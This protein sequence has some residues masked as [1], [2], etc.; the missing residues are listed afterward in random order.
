[1][2]PEGQ[3]ATA[4]YVA[5]AIYMLLVFGIGGYTRRLIRG[6]EDYFACGRRVPWW[7]AAISHHISG[8]SAF[9]FVGFA[10]VGYTHGFSV[11]TLFAIPCFIAMALGAFVW[12]PRW[13]RLAVITPAQYLEQRFNNLVRQLI[14]WSGI[15]VKFV[16]EGAK[17]YSLAKVVSACTRLRQAHVV[18]G[19][20]VITIAYLLLGGLWAE[21]MTD[22][23]QFFVQFSITLL[24]VPVVLRAVGGWGG[25]WR[26]QPGQYTLFSSEVP[27]ARVLVYLPV[28]IMSY[29]GGTWGLAQRFYSLGRPRDATKAALLSAAL[30]LVYP[31]AIYIPVWAAPV[32]LGEIDPELSYILV[33]AKY[34][35]GLAP[36]LLGLLLAAIFAATMS[37]VDSD[38][39]A[40]AAV[41]TKDIYGRIINPRATEHKL[42]KVGLIATVVFGALTIGCGLAVG[43]PALGGAFSAMIEWY[44]AVLGPVSI[45]LLFGMVLR[46]TT[47]RGALLSWAGGFVTFVAFKYWLVDLL[48]V[49]LFGMTPADAGTHA[50]AI[51]WCIYTGAELF[52]AFAIFVGEGYLHTYRSYRRGLD[53]HREED[54]EWA[55]RWWSHSSRS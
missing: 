21:M 27:L 15:A 36:G 51:A 20:G 38:L 34:L 50:Q 46:R 16:D 31:L 28:V 53:P 9:A 32:L 25:M 54:R 12:A 48:W 47:W 22:S 1:M 2:L 37:M 5:L 14:A 6:I 41:F 29:N 43:G 10:S 24:L 49:N 13:V 33:A 55:E 44:G 4:D 3:L 18:V 11:W 30:F 52:V 40:L 42:M 23:L 8:Y 26:Q 17:L 45:P 7:M 39:N 19:A 35:P